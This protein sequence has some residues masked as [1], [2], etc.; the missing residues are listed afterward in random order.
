[1]SV[2]IRLDISLAEITMKITISKPRCL[3]GNITLK[4][5]TDVIKIL[6]EDICCITFRLRTLRKSP[7]TNGELTVSQVNIRQSDE[8]NLFAKD[9]LKETASFDVS[10]KSSLEHL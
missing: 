7:F 2:L 4:K 6:F 8:K 10:E 3:C 5:S 9:N 1:M